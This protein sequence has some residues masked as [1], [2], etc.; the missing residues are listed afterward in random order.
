[1]ERVGTRLRRRDETL[2]N[3]LDVYLERNYDVVMEGVS[4]YFY[5]SFSMWLV[6]SIPLAITVSEVVLF[7]SEL[8]VL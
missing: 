7:I 5:G 6:G 4:G 2:R 1:M 3:L 8:N